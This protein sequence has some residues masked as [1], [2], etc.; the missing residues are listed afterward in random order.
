MAGTLLP[1][2][3]LDTYRDAQARRHRDWASRSRRAEDLGIPD[4]QLRA[5]QRERVKE[6]TRSACYRARVG[7]PAQ[8]GPRLLTP[9]CWQNGEPDDYS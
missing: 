7:V 4:A 6:E 2:I 3:T 9:R 5:W 8:P 1:F